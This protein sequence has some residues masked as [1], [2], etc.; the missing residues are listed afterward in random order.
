MLLSSDCFWITISKFRLVTGP[1]WPASDREGSKIYHLFQLQIGYVLK[2]VKYRS[3][4]RC[5]KA[6]FWNPSQ[7]APAFWYSWESGKISAV[8]H[9]PSRPGCLPDRY[10]ENL[11]RWQVCLYI[12]WTS[13]YVC[14]YPYCCF[15]VHFL[16]SSIVVP[17]FCFRLI[18]FGVASVLQ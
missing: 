17:I 3:S 9:G 15:H 12:F 16:M 8:W 2:I 14:L 13:I 10:I 18:D 1:G 7:G 6:N 5:F 11:S 4:H